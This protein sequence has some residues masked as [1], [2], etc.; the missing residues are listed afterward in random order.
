MEQWH[1]LAERDPAIAAG[2]GGNGPEPWPKGVDEPVLVQ[3][4]LDGP[5][6]LEGCFDAKRATGFAVIIPLKSS[7]ASAESA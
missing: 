5:D 2:P 4:P 7:V 6:P 1:Q 3:G